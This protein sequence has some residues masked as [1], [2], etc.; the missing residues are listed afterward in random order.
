ME[1]IKIDVSENI[2][3]VVGKPSRI[4]S[5]LVG[6]PI[7]FSFDDAWNGMKKTAVFKAGCVQR[8]VENLEE[9]TVVPWEVL[10]TE[11][12]W[13]SVGV[14]GVNNDGSVAIP[15]IW[16]NVSVIYPGVDPEADPGTTPSLPVWQRVL[17][18]IGNLLGLTTNNKSDLVGAI[19]EVHNIALAGGV[20]T[21]TTLTKKGKAAEAK[22]TGD[23]INAHVSDSRNP[24][25]VT[26]EQI[27][28]ADAKYVEARMLSDEDDLLELVEPGRYACKDDEQAKRISFS[29][30]DK[31]FTMDV[32]YT[33]G[34]GPYVVQELKPRDKSAW[35]YRQFVPYSEMLNAET[36]ALYDR[37][38]GL[39]PQN[40]DFYGQH[41]Y[42]WYAENL[43]TKTA[44]LESASQLY[45]LADIVNGTNGAT[46]DTLE[47]WTIKLGNDIVVNKGDASE[48]DGNASGVYTWTRIGVNS[49]DSGSTRNFRGTFD[50][51][52]HY[53]SGLHGGENNNNGLFGFT[54][55][56][57]IKNLAVINS[58]FATNASNGQ[59]LGS[60]AAR[61]LSGGT[62]KNVYSDAI[63]V[64]RQGDWFTGGVAGCVK[65]SKAD[66][67]VFAGTIFSDEE[68]GK[69]NKYIGGIT[70][71]SDSGGHSAELTNCLFIGA[72]ESNDS[73]VGG[74][75][76][77]L[78]PGSVVDGCV[79]AGTI[80]G[81][82]KQ[83]GAVL[84]WVS[85]AG[86]H[87]ITNCYYSVDLDLE[88]FA[89]SDAGG[90]VKTTGSKVLPSA[91]VENSMVPTK[92]AKVYD[93]ENKPTAEDVGSAPAVVSIEGLGCYYRI[94]DG[95]KEW[96]NPPMASG[97]EYRTTERWAGRAVY[98]YMLNI[99]ALPNAQMAQIAHGLPATHI[100]RCE[101]VSNYGVAIP[102]VSNQNRIEL[103]C[104]KNN[105]YVTTTED[106]SYAQAYITIY[107][108]K[109]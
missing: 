78:G 108:T 57:T 35:M 8:I 88:L 53:I 28:A 81:N 91:C 74:I 77:M 70:G 66:S 100:I 26:A 22:A 30:V 83:V 73:G 80:E 75:A 89:G 109:D 15:T 90:V 50:G 43:S 13:L 52:G 17:N 101:G 33:N 68:T 67:C 37:V 3:R 11:G 25:N 60:V 45:G 34:V 47:G 107:Y 82:A 97:V 102:F 10:E 49:T 95:E 44:I 1:N 64:S 12:V 86:N 31:A 84:G 92:W 6:L 105:I 71:G 16:A 14:Y 72:I 61:V 5:G 38:H 4:T 32:K 23:R 62:L 42:S 93:S 24:H 18:S 9:E 104:D 39:K 54:Y 103:G 58:Y 63:L 106:Y 51:Q 41:D 21:D 7:V 76:G 69:N 40:A 20:E 2:A 96:I 99:G 55:G 98:C 56:A 59:F 65:Y 19:N 29:P 87:M 85:G 79:S 94:T 48:W 36:K 46:Q 27:G